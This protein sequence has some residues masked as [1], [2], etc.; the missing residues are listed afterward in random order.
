MHPISILYFCLWLALGRTVKEEKILMLKTSK[1][2]MHSQWETDAAAAME[3]SIYEQH[4]SSNSGIW[5]SISGKL[6]R[7]RGQITCYG[8]YGIAYYIV[9]IN[10]GSAAQWLKLVRKRFESHSIT[11]GHWSEDS[12]PMVFQLFN[13]TLNACQINGRTDFKERWFP[14]FLSIFSWQPRQY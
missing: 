14:P 10:Q 1:A 11:I 9:S 2:K 12:G 8:Y 6:S 5:K 3:S 7:S 13:K 4:S